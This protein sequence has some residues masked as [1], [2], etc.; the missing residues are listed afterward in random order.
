MTFFTFTP[1]QG[2]QKENSTDDILAAATFPNRVGLDVLRL[3][4]ASVPGLYDKVQVLGSELLQCELEICQTLPRPFFMF[5]ALTYQR[6]VAERL[7]LLL[8]QSWNLPN[9]RRYAVYIVHVPSAIHLAKL[10]VEICVVQR[11]SDLTGDVPW[12]SEMISFAF[13][14]QS[15]MLF[16]QN[17]FADNWERSEPGHFWKKKKLLRSLR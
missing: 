6:V 9:Y 13:S 15:A 1:F 4:R 3:L 2:A 11:F 14:L 10:R 5:E 16:L 7:G 12:T 17:N 8:S